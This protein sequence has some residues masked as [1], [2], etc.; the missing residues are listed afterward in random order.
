MINSKNALHLQHKDPLKNEKTALTA[1]F[2]Y[3]LF[4]SAGSIKWLLQEANRLI[5]LIFAAENLTQ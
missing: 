5:F 2:L 1:A 3:L 4:E